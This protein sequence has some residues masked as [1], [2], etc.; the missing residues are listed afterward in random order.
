VIFMDEGQVIE[1]GPPDQVLDHPKHER[2]Q[3]FLRMVERQDQPG[4]TNPGHEL[5]SIDGIRTA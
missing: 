5:T 2:T 1:E 4:S 3:R